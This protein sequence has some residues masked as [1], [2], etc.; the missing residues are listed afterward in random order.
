MRPVEPLALGGAGQVRIALS[1]PDD[2]PNAG[3]YD[4]V[5][6]GIASFT[7]GQFQ[8]AALVGGSTLGLVPGQVGAL[9]QLFGTVRF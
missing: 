7:M 9:G 2:A 5:G 8:L 4:V 1:K 6:G 3:T